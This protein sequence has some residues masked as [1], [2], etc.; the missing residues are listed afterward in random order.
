MKRTY[1]KPFMESEEFVTNEYVAACFFPVCNRWGCEYNDDKSIEIKGENLQM[2]IDNYLEAHGG[3][4]DTLHGNK[5]HNLA[6]WPFHE[7]EGNYYHRPT[8][9]QIAD[10]CHKLDFE[11][12]GNHS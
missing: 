11:N 12:N 2:A 10:Y 3:G 8:F 4:N 5:E 9:G 6:S 1:I 7:E